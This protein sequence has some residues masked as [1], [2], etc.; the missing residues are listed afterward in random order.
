MPVVFRWEGYRFFFFSNEGDPQEPMHIHVR[1]G[2]RVA[3]F[4]IRPEVVCSE[5]Y[6]LTSSELHRLAQVIE[7]HVDLV[8][9]RGHEQ[10]GD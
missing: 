1:K 5:S 2:D 7:S 6:G 9:R 4:W 3:K 10:F 8:E